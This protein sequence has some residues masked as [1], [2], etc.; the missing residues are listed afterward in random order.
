MQLTEMLEK[1]ESLRSALLQDT[2]KGRADADLDLRLVKE[3]ILSTG[4][5]RVTLRQADIGQIHL[6]GGLSRSLTAVGMGFSSLDLD[7]ASLEWRI[8][9]GVFDISQCLITGPVLNLAVDGYIDLRAQQIALQANVML[10]R[11]LASQVF[12]P[13]GDSFQFDLT[14]NLE[15]PAWQVRMNPLRWFQ[16]RLFVSPEPEPL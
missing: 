15:N 9:D 11:G 10:F 3:A 4:G 1:P 6:L 2:T 7:S 14:G 8:Q 13:V 12:A 5:G 16:N